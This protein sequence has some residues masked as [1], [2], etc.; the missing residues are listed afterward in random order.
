MSQLYGFN[1]FIGREDLNT[2]FKEFTFNKS[3]LSIDNQHAETLC[4]TSGFIF[5]SNVEQNLKKYIGTYIPKYT[6]AFINTGIVGSLYIGVNDYGLVKGIP[7]QGNLPIESIKKQILHSAQ[8][9]VTNNMGQDFDFEKLISIDVLKLEHPNVP[10][11]HC[12]PS[13]HTYLAQKTEFMSRY[14]NFVAKFENWKIRYNFFTQKLTDLVNNIES[15]LALTEYIRRIDPTNP[16]IKLLESDFVLEHSDH[17]LIMELKDDSTKIYYWV[18][19]WKDEMTN[20]MKSTKPEFD[21]PVFNPSVPRNLLTNVSEMI[22]YWIHNN[23]N[24]NL[25]LIRIRF[26]TLVA[27]FGTKKNSQMIFSYQSYY[28]KNWISCYRNILPNGEPVCTPF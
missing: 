24:M 21:E 27:T 9:Y 5:N 10:H 1:D 23:S 28:D 7:Y 17:E 16:V 19:R 20:L 3:R 13:F 26:N 14:T 4:Q 25:Y 8:T 12:A 15:R 22:P 11:N 6:C 18:C 2:E